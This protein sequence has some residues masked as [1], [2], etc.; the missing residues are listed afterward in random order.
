LRLRALQDHPLRGLVR[1]QLDGAVEQRL[2]LDHAGALDAARGGDDDRWRGVV[3]PSREL[4]RGEAAEHHGVHG[5]EAG[6]G[7]HRDHRRG[8]HRQ[9]DDHPVA[10]ADAEAGQHARE[11][12]HLVAQLGVG[13]RAGRA[14]DRRVVHESG[15]VAVASVDVAVQRVVAD[16]QLAV[17]EPAE[18]RWARRVQ[19]PARGPVPVD[20]LRGLQPERLRIVEAGPPLRLVPAHWCTLLTSEPGC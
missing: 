8:H 13:V 12:R 19:R 3:D 4:A 20:G 10:A 7:Q 15:L 5:T 6:A 1:G 2:V 17:G 9:I 11:P 18:E 16:V 14:G